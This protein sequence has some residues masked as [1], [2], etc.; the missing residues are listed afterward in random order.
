MDAIKSQI[1]NSMTLFNIAIGLVSIGYALEGRYADSAGLI[2]VSAVFD[3]LDG[4]VARKFEATS[5]TGEYLDTISDFIAFGLAAPLLMHMA[6][7]V[8][9]EVAILFSLASAAR[10]CM[11]MMADTK[12]FFFGI[13]T[14]ASGCIIS[15]MALAA[16]SD[17]SF[18]EYIH[19]MP[20]WAVNTSMLALS[21]L[22]V[23]RAR[24]IKFE[25][26]RGRVRTFI[27]LL[28]STIFIFDMGFFFKALFASC[29]GY[30]I[31]GWIPET[32][33]HRKN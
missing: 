25:I 6:F 13:P 28:L 29:I 8:S 15:S 31:F 33:T 2:L 5:R 23:S 22:M 20:L 16:Y 21:A 4:Y 30:G 7:G 11:F 17:A 18:A 32:I 10:L 27:M 19:S 14:T 26:R 12:S 9:Q 24:Y 1:P 3:S